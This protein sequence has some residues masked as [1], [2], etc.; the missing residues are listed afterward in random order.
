MNQ[1]FQALLLTLTLILI[2]CSG[3]EQQKKIKPEG[4]Y[5]YTVLDNSGRN[6]LEGVFIF[7]KPDKSGLM[8]CSNEI[9]E[10][11]DTN[12][13]ISRR[14][15]TNIE[16]AFYDSKAKKISIDLNPY[17]QDDNIYITIDLSTST[18]SGSWIH[19]TFA[20]IKSQGEIKIK[21]TSN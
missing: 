18:P 17:I 20:G 11:T 3:S 9:K 14:F 10:I 12:S 1:I 21:K 7:S 13:Y 19:S 5:N 8:K 16:Q 15:N 6:M 4:R 2:S